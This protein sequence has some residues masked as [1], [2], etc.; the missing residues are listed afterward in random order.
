[1][2]HS[3][4]FRAAYI[5]AAQTKRNSFGIVVVKFGEQKGLRWTCYGAEQS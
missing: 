4:E 1:M 5:A 2:T 3:F